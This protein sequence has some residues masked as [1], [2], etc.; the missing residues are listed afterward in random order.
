MG[1]VSESPKYVIA[2]AYSLEVLQD[3]VNELLGD[4]YYYQPVGNIV[5]YDKP[6]EGL[7]FVQVL[8]LV[9][10]PKGIT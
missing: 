4:A 9:R 1:K 7:E 3:K 2:Q 8:I 6:V 5:F 10:Q